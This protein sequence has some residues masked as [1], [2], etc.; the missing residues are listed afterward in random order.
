[1]MPL[2]AALSIAD[3]ALSSAADAFSALLLFT[4][5][6]TLFERV[7]SIFLT[8]LFRASRALACRF[9]FIADLFFLTGA[10][11]ANILPPLTAFSIG[12]LP[13]RAAPLNLRQVHF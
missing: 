6:S 13:K 2:R 3:T 7:F 9:L 10:A 8:D 5:A 12:N 1:M 11:P 4:S